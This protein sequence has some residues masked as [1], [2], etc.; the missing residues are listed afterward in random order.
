[1]R[2]MFRYTFKHTGTGNIE[3]KVY[4]LKQLEEREVE[5]LSPCFNA[6]HGYQLIGRD[7]F[8]GFLDKDGKEIYENDSDGFYIVKMGQFPVREHETGGIIDNAVG[9]YLDPIDKSVEP[10]NWEIPLNN[11][12]LNRLD[13][14]FN[15]NIYDNPELL[16]N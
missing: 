7:G 6:N 10:F 11:F 5:K 15:K 13:D 3:K 1:M 14:G 4:T 2:N 9:W 12:W 8:T 16:G